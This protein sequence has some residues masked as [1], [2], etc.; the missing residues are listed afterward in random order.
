MPALAVAPVSA[1]VGA[2]WAFEWGSVFNVDGETINGYVT[3]HLSARRTDI[4]VTATWKDGSTV[5]A[6]V[7]EPAMIDTLAA[8]ATS[9]FHIHKPQPVEAAWTLTVAVSASTSGGSTPVGGLS[10]QPGEFTAGA[11]YEGMITNDGSVVAN[12]VQVYGYRRDTVVTDAAGSAVIDS[13]D[14]GETVTYSIAF[15]EAR[16]GDVEYLVAQTTSGNYLT[17]WNNYFG[18]LGNSS[19]TFVEA[20]VWMADQGITTGCGN[21][22]FCPK[23]AVTRAQMAV[24]L[25]RALAL[26]DT[27][28]VGF[29]DIASLSQDFQDAINALANADITEGC[30]TAPLRY[31]PSSSVTRGQMSKFI[32]TGYG[33]EGGKDIAPIAGPGPF[34]DDNGHF[35]EPYNNAMAEAGITDGC[36]TAK[37]CPNA[38]VTREQMAVFVMRASDLPDAP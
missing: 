23:A 34:T 4:Q 22:N 15:D 21:A 14:P 29:T 8:H 11:T 16:S 10:V 9:P 2:G 38:N 18:D 36:G 13:I 24:F 12:D 7:T 5:M 20:I 30:D 3:N 33:D 6:T 27:T 1:H 26:G 17:S 28:P 35:S 32:V 25:S 31:C 19:D 37:Y